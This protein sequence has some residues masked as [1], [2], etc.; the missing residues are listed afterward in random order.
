MPVA[1]TNHGLAFLEVFNHEVQTPAAA[2]V[3][4]VA[5]K[6][7][8]FDYHDERRGIVAVWRRDG[9]RQEL[10]VTDLVFGPDAVAAW[11]QPAYP[12]PALRRR[13]ASTDNRRGSWLTGSKP[14]PARTRLGS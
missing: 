10:A 3:L 8:G 4:G 2:T 11:V 13:K 12:P 5:I 9:A 14:R 7:V 6:V 1:T